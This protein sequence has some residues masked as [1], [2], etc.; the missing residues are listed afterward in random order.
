MGKSFSKRVFNIQRHIRKGSGGM[1]RTVYYRKGY[2][3][4]INNKFY[5]VSDGKTITH[6]GELRHKPTLQEV[7]NKT[8]RLNQEREKMWRIDEEPKPIT[9]YT[10]L[11]IIVGCIIAAVLIIYT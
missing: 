7:W 2:K 4:G 11:Q 1:K 9:K 3:V 6:F 8:I 10:I 5:E